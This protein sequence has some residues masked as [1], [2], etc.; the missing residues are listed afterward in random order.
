M[1][2]YWQTQRLE[3]KN[4][5]INSIQQNYSE[6]LEEFPFHVDNSNEYDAIATSAYHSDE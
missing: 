4:N 2:G 5:L 3:W 6:Y 1:L